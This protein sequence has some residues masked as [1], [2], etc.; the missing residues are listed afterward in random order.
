MRVI[1]V[2]YSVKEN[3]KLSLKGRYRPRELQKVEAPRIIDNRHLNKASLSAL[4]TVRLYSYRKDPWYL[5]VLDS[6]S[7][8][9]L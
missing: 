5:F 8:P 7:T 9:L 6:E 4:P 3:L 1:S 2:S